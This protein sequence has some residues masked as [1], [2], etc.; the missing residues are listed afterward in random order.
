MKR[1]SLV[2]VL[3]VAGPVAGQQ[4]DQLTKKRISDLEKA[5]DQLEQRAFRMEK[6]FEEF[7]SRTNNKL[8]AILTAVQG[9][10]PLIPSP[11]SADGPPNSMSAGMGTGANGVPTGQA[12]VFDTPWSAG[13]FVPISTLI[14]GP[15]TSVQSAPFMTSPQQQFFLPQSA[16]LSPYS[17]QVIREVV[18]VQ[19]KSSTLSSGCSGGS[20]G[21][22]ARRGVFR[23]RG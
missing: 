23:F 22:G 15:G 16:Q 4:D 5:V 20:C 10:K 9:G 19:S 7:E 13:R 8:D 1:L 12:L 11:A 21:G 18:Q 17:P 6:K 14:H 3:L 2:I